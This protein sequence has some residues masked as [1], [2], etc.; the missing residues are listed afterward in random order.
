MLLPVPEGDE[1][2]GIEWTRDGRY[3]L[4]TGS[5]PSRAEQ[6]GR[7]AGRGT[8]QILRVPVEGG[9]P[10]SLGSIRS[11]TGPRLHPDGRQIAYVTGTPQY[12][13]WV[14]ENIPGVGPAQISSPR[15]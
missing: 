15:P 9:D 10:V 7:A 6:G 13:L 14:M 11:T 12:E 8:Q 3:L 1:V 2:G 4:I 5:F